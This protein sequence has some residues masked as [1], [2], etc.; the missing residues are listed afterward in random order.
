MEQ[1][2]QINMCSPAF[3]DCLLPRHDYTHTEEEVLSRPSI[4]TLLC[5]FFAFV[6]HDQS[7]T[8]A[9]LPHT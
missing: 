6:T 4:T 5:P 2:V 9:V 1:H 3:V 8:N 7:E